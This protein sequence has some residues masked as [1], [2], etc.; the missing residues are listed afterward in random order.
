MTRWRIVER[1]R[2]DVADDAV[3]PKKPKNAGGQ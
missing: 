3:P 2:T 1:I